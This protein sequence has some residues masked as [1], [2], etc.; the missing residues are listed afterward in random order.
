M[1]LFEKGVE[2]EDY[3]HVSFSK[4][5][6]SRSDFLDKAQFLAPYFDTELTWF[7]FDKKNSLRNQL[8]MV[9]SV[10]KKTNKLIG[11]IMGDGSTDES[12]CH[13]VH[14]NPGIPLELLS[15]FRGVGKFIIDKSIMEQEA[16]AEC[17]FSGSTGL[18]D[19]IF[20]YHVND[21]YSYLEFH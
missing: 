16:I 3:I 7:N 10:N 11:L 15:K 2:T 12:Q 9:L 6:K 4:Y 19:E 17:A 14:E 8:K 1:N 13:F 5:L 20:S 18:K 21:S